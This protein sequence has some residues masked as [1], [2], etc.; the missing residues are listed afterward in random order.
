VGD[1]ALHG[2]IETGEFHTPTMAAGAR[3]AATRP[4]A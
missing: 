4:S 3:G 2:D 1:F